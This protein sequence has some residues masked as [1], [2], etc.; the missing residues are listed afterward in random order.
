VPGATDTCGNPLIASFVTP[1]MVTEAGG[2]LGDREPT[3]C[4][5][6]ACDAIRHGT[7]EVVL[8]NVRFDG[9]LDVVVN[10]QPDPLTRTPALWGS[11]IGTF[12][13]DLNPGFLQVPVMLHAE[14]FQF[15]LF[16]VL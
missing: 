10:I 15:G 3:S 11:L 2:D 14:Q 9:M 7:V 5:G 4:D 16:G 8:S 6:G 13:S 1:P 12:L